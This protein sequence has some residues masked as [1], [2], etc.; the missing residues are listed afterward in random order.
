[1]SLCGEIG[2]VST[3]QLEHA[4]SEWKHSTIDKNTTDT[5]VNTN[6]KTFNNWYKYNW[7]KYKYNYKYKPA[8]A[9]N[10]VKHST[11]GN[12]LTIDTNI[13]ETNTIDT[14]T[15]DTNTNRNSNININTKQ[16]WHTM[17]W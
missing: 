5:N 13:I 8:W 4:M 16:S 1:M 14:N 15:I 6:T 12:K 10:I 7:Y 11:L 2:G 3:K 9:H 17:S